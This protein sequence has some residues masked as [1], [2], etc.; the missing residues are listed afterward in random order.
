[1]STHRGYYQGMQNMIPTAISQIIESISKCVIGLT[2]A[3]AVKAHFTDEFLNFGTVLGRNYDSFNEALVQILSLSAAGAMLGVTISIFIGWMYLLIHRR[4][5]GDNITADQYESS[6]KADTDRHLLKQIVGIGIPITFA[7]IATQIIFFIG[8]AI[9]QNRLIYSLKTDVDAV[10]ASHKGWLEYMRIKVTDS[11]GKIATDLVGCYSFGDAFFFLAPSLSEP[12]KMSALPHVA[13]SWLK[14]DIQKTQKHIGI[15][16]KLTAM[17]ASPI[18]FGISALGTPIMYLVYARRNT[19]EVA[20]GGPLLSVLAAASVFLAIYSAS[21]T[22]LNAIGRHD[23]PVKLLTAG[24]ALNLI[25]T[26]I[27]VGIPSIN[28]KGAPIGNVAGYILIAIL[29][30]RS[31]YRNTHIRM[32]LWN[33][34]FKPMLA[35]LFCG[36]SAYLAYFL[37]MTFLYHVILQRVATMISIAFGGLI[38]LIS[39]SLL[40]V[41][42]KEELET[43]IKANRISG[44]LTKLRIVR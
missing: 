35:G 15:T 16:L 8:N 39:I 20:V 9:T 23:V 40:R 1:M 11:F 17:I 18:G 12:L 34:L 4:V 33:S 36:L 3:Y 22:I 37:Q 32:G 7:V 13:E 31:V 5:H 26:Y 30:L 6:P 44:I 14:G 43:V 10:F 41:L 38:Y 19:A 2:A 29:S 28:I 24:G 25:I 21:N 42:S 27:L